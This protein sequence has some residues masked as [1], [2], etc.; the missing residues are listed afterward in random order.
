MRVE[1]RGRR[2]RGTGTLM[3]TGEGHKGVV[4]KGKSA[5]RHE[6]YLRSWSGTGEDKFTLESGILVL[7]KGGQF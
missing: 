5:K 1:R 2:L 4:L 7:L 3:G 6:G